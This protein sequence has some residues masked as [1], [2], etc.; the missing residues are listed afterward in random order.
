[1]YN[2]VFNL[3]REDINVKKNTIVLVLRIILQEANRRVD[4]AYA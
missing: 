4:Q 3:R 2:N 1:M